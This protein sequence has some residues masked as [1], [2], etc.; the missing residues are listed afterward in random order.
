MFWCRHQASESWSGGSGDGD[1]ERNL[2]L[3][4]AMTLLEQRKQ[5]QRNLRTL[6]QRT[7]NSTETPTHGMYMGTLTC[8]HAVTILIVFT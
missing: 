8:V 1:A 6:Q 5:L 3:R 2:R 4:K 7:A